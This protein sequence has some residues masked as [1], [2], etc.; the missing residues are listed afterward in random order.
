MSATT[1]HA[2]ISLRLPHE[3]DVFMKTDAWI[4][5]WPKTKLYRQVE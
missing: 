2:A 1:E 4:P 5:S 3:V